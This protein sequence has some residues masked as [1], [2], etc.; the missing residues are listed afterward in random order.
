MSTIT[1]DLIKKL[2]EQTSA[3]V[4]DCR[5][6]LEEAG[7]DLSKASEILRKKGL[8][9][10][11]KKEGRAVSEGVIVSYVHHTGRVGAMVELGSE[12]DF[13]GRNDEFRALA[14][15]IAMQ[16]AS[17]NPEHIE[18]LLGQSYIRDQKITIGDM[19]KQS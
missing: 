6:A 16:V 12:T 7:G 2:R 19:L 15:E 3:G 17:M 11:A 13:V 14:Q 9:K 8:D 1:L 10:A 18:G 5:V 4:L